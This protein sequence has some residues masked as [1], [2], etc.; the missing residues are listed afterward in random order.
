MRSIPGKAS[1]ATLSLW[2]RVARNE[3]GEG[4]VK[5]SAAGDDVCCQTGFWFEEDTYVS[6]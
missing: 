1:G 5:C 6:F 2:E 3:P 4:G